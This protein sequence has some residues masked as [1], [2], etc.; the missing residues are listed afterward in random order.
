MQMVQNKTIAM[1]AG[2]VLGWQGAEKYSDDLALVAMFYSGMGK[3]PD[4][5]MQA[6]WDSLS[7]TIY[8]ALVA[9]SAVLL[10]WLTKNAP[11]LI[12]Q[13]RGESIDTA[14]EGKKDAI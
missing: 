5:V 4:D 12:E 2:G 1:L 14:V 13:L 9:G 10:R 3:V 6:V 11:D 7:T 8:V